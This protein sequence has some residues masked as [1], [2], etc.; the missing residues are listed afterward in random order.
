[1]QVVAFNVSLRS[2]VGKKATKNVR[3]EGMIPCVMYGGDEVR[4]FSTTLNDIKHLIYTPDFKLAEITLEGVVYRCIVKEVQ[5]HPLTENINHIDFLQLV[6]GNTIRVQIPVRFV[7]VSP[8]VKVGGKLVQ[9]VRRI[10]VKTTPEHLVDELSADISNLDLNQ[11]IRVKDI[12]VGEKIEVMVSP[13]IP[14]ATVETPR[15]L[16]SAAT[17]DKPGDKKKK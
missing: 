17:A 4:Y 16:R 5:Y 15:A 11:S 10:L 2:E 13:S 14:V 12:K 1:M 6:E 9:K 7:G 8:G 3:K